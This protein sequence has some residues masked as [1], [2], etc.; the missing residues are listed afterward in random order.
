GPHVDM[1]S[2]LALADAMRVSRPMLGVVLVRSRVD[3]TALTDALRA[4]VREVVKERD[5]EG[6]AAAVRRTAE[7][8]AA[9]RQ[10]AGLTVTADE[11]PPLGT[12]ITVFSAKGGAGKTTVSTNLAAALAGNG[13]REVCL[14][15]LDLAFGDVAIALQLFPAHTLSDA[16][17]LADSLDQSGVTALLTPHSPGL[18]TLVAPVEPG[19][20]ESIPAAL[21]GK[22]LRLLKQMFAY[23]VVDTPPAF[24]DHVLAAFDES[25][26]VALLATLDI[27]ALK[28]LKLTLETLDLLNYPRDRWRVV[29]NRADSKVGLQLS[30]VE[31]TLRVPIAAQIPSS[32]SVPASINRGVPIVLDEP[33][34]PVSVAIK[35]FA[36]DFLSAAPAASAAAGA[37]PPALRADQ[38]RF[39]LRRNK[40]HRG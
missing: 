14:V 17:S 33:G 38:R 4:G 13:A 11:G 15:D 6:L 19:A 1:E 21:V 10:Q 24:T 30:E 2:A 36:N 7:L 9:V 34:H 23:V 26:Y 3:T 35:Q 32:R 8:A 40:E 37:L 18:T 31:K 16:V 25:D 12:V 29:L 27:P 39:T 28:N 5:V 20:A 22:V